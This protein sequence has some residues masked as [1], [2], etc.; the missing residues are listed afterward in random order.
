MHH[1]IEKIEKKTAIAAGRGAGADKVNSI[2][3]CSQHTRR[4]GQRALALCEQRTPV[5]TLPPAVVF[6]A[7]ATTRC[8]L[9]H[10]LCTYCSA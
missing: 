8:S 6:I 2:N 3:A 5:Q 10:G 4:T 1:K 7:T 9:G